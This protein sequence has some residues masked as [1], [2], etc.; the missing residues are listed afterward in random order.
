MYLKL[1]SDKEDL[2]AHLNKIPISLSLSGMG[3]FSPQEYPQSS[4]LEIDLLRQ[5]VQ[6][7]CIYKLYGKILRSTKIG[8]QWEIGIRFINMNHWMEN[9]IGNFLMNLERGIEGVD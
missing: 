5:A 7:K 3:F 1:L 4:I 2:E 8:S 6:R 9:E